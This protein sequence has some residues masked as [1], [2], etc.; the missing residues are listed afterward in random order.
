MIE[1]LFRGLFSGGGGRDV[2][3]ELISTWLAARIGCAAGSLPA[4]G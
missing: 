2:Q 1:Y 3:N 4:A